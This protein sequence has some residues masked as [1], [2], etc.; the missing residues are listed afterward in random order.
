MMQ[1]ITAISLL[2]GLLGIGQ[3]WEWFGH[4]GGWLIGLPLMV[5]VFMAH[6]EGLRKG[7]E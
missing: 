1:A 7:R 3:I 5:I 6:D 4:P 2:V